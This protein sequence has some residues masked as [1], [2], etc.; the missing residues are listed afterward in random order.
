MLTAGS[1]PTPPQQR[2]SVPS[3][4]TWVVVIP[5]SNNSGSSCQLQ[6]VITSQMAQFGI[7]VH[8]QRERHAFSFADPRGI[9]S[10]GGLGWLSAASALAQGR[11]V[12]GWSMG[13][14]AC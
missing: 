6:V 4:T 13:C 1:A 9:F 8:S 11:G 14:D 12:Q 5:K 2:W 3:V 10:P 7:S